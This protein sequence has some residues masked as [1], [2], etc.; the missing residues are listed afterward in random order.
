MPV[1]IKGPL[2]EQ[3]YRN[4]AAQLT[5]L[6]RVQEDSARAKSAG[7]ECD[8]QDTVCQYIKER[9]ERIKG[10]YFPDKP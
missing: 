10:V 4:I 8:E 6:K 3:D 7:F 5:E 2:T 1:P 9:L